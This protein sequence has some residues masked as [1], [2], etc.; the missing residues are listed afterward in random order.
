MVYVIQV[1]G[2]IGVGKTSLIQNLKEK[3]KN[4]TCGRNIKF[5]CEPIDSWINV[6]NDGDDNINMLQ[7]YYSNKEEYSEMFQY[8]AFI[9]LLNNN[10]LSN[11]DDDDIIVTERSITTSVYCF[12]KLLLNENYVRSSF[13]KILVKG[14]EMYLPKIIEPNIIIYIEVDNKDISTILQERIKKR[15]RL[16]EFENISDDYLLKLNNM[17]NDYINNFV[18]NNNNNKNNNSNNN[19][20]PI[21]IKVPID[22]PKEKEDEYISKILKLV[23][24]QQS[25]PVSSASF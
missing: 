10:L 15:N 20:P 16:E 2:N 19:N 24:R 21:I 3:F 1:E 6:N 7:L 23:P 5:L 4:T 22:T 25:L 13:Y 18:N 14:L 8:W 17:Y 12:A 11:F 9:T